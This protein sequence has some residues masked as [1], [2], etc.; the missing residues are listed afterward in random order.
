MWPMPPS[1]AP[2]T[3]PSWHRCGDSIRVFPKDHIFTTG[4]G[5]SWVGLGVYGVCAAGLW[6]RVEA[7]GSCP[8]ES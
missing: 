6:R 4:C 5:V 7:D 1:V 3:L 2:G 8:S